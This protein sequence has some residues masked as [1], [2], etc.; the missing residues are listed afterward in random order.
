VYSAS[1]EVLPCL[2]F[3]QVDHWR[4]AKGVRPASSTK[5]LLPCKDHLFFSGA[6]PGAKLRLD[7]PQSLKTACAAMYRDFC[8][9]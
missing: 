3:G 7:I 8:S 4:N 2:A 5:I 6:R 9:S 1:N